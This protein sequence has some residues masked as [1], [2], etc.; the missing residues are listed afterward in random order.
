MASRG[1]TSVLGLDLGTNSI[2]WALLDED[3]Q[4]VQAMGTRIF[5]SPMDAKEK[6]KPKNA[7][8]RQARAA[9][10]LTRRRVIRRNQLLALL[11]EHGFIPAQDQTTWHQK[12]PYVLRARGLD[13]ELSPE[14]FGRALFHLAQRRGYQSNR[15]S[16]G[17]SDVEDPAVQEIIE[18]KEAEERLKEL[19]ALQRK[20]EKAAAK[21]KDANA[22]EDE[23]VV[24]AAIA[25][26]KQTLENQ[27][28][29]TLGEYF[30]QRLQKGLPVRRQ[31]TE[32][33]MYQYEFNA[34]WAAQAQFHPALQS[35]ELKAQFFHAI[36]FQRPLRRAVGVVGACQFEKSRNRAPKANPISHEFRIWQQLNHLLYLPEGS[37]DWLAL[38]LEQK[39]LVAD[40]LHETKEL[41]WS[42]FRALT[43]IKK[44]A[45]INL[46]PNENERITG[47]K[48]LSGNA[49]HIELVKRTGGRW[50]EMNEDERAA[51]FED[52]HTIDHKGK[53]VRRLRQHWQFTPEETYDL[54]TLELEMGHTMLSTRAMRRLLTHLKQGLNYHDAVVAAGYEHN[55]QKEIAVKAQLPEVPKAI[56]N[57]V[58]R[59][60][61]N[62][63]RRLVNAII[64]EYGLPQAIRIEMGRDLALNKKD[65][66]EIEK[67]NKRN[68]ELNQ[69][70]KTACQAQGIAH[71]SVTDL[72]KYRLWVECNGVCPYTGREI[73]LNQLF[74][75]DI[76]IEHILPFSRSQDD[77]MANKTLCYARENREVKRN[78]TPFEAYGDSPQWDEMRQRVARFKCGR[79]KKKLFALTAI[80]EGFSERQLNDTRYIARQ[81]LQFCQDLGCDVTVTTGKATAALRHHWGLNP[82][83]GDDGQ[84]NRLDHRHHALDAVVV[85]LTTLSLSQRITRAAQGH[86]GGFFDGAWRVPEPWE[87]FRHD[88]RQ[89]LDKVVVSH[90]LNRK[91][92]GALH[93]ETA[94][95]RRAADGSFVVRKPVQSITGAEIERVID[96][97]LRERIRAWVEEVGPKRQASEPFYFVNRHGEKVEVRRVR[98]RAR[99]ADPSKMFAVRDD[100]GRPVKYHPYGSNHHV[101]IYEHRV[102]GERNA[103]VITMVEAARRGAQ[104]E[105]VY[106]PR[107]PVGWR[108]LMVLHKG[109]AVTIAESDSV[110]IVRSFNVENPLDMFV[111]EHLTGDESR[112]IRIR[113]KSG[114]ARLAKR[115]QVDRVGRVWADP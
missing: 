1:K 61:L 60:A 47:L 90:Q 23:K 43:G 15:K 106:Q 101:V 86:T 18:R 63:T 82:L 104:R 45:Q 12:E 19:E 75:Q 74:T 64:A 58:V 40:A 67:A 17:L 96:P 107:P 29:R 79:H 51:L 111:R 24:L 89:A 80:P 30:H 94:Y 113:G 55:Y 27:G 22:P 68:A 110:Y 103:E 108:T 32:R 73:G 84:K 85:A 97:T 36:F 95:G 21:G 112:D 9:R 53:L 41:S 81:V 102:T 70:A 50:T 88:V 3:Q 34:L 7:A 59:K 46:E 54:A 99:A 28:L 42:K 48:S 39:Q 91:V 37:S 100:A 76:D 8:R 92:Y 72:Q 5:S 13:E 11:R 57:P 71:P 69:Q 109:D 78:R 6:D 93:E 16:A 33:G 105:N 114:L 35:D 20:R 4:Q 49:T 52:L 38:A 14:E 2:G 98:V 44:T 83:L 56:T 26:L 115:V 87:G 10:R 31:Y 62:E 77:S 66:Q 65:R 25:E